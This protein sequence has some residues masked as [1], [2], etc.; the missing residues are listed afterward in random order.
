M[1]TEI[2]LIAWTSS[3]NYSVEEQTEFGGRFLTAL[4]VGVTVGAVPGGVQGEIGLSAAGENVEVVEHHDVAMG[5]I[6]QPA[7]GGFEPVVELTGERA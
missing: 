2:N 1:P 5:I 3:V 7:V 6:L 4:G